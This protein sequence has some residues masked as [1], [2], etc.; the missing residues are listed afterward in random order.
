MGQPV[1]SGND[2]DEWKVWLFENAASG[3]GYLADQIAAAMGKAAGDSRP[4]PSKRGT[5]A[6]SL[7]TNSWPRITDRITTK[8]SPWVDLVAREVEFSPNA[9]REVYHAVMTPDYVVILALT[10]D[11]RIPLVRQ[12]RPAVEDFTLEFP[13]GIIDAGEDAAT[14]ARRE[15]L[16]ETGFPAKR[17]Y[18][19]GVNKT[20]AGRLSNRVHSYLIETAAQVPD[21]KPEEGLTTSLVTSSELLELVLRGEFDAQTDLGTVLLAVIHGRLKLPNSRRPAI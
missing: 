8:V 21:F 14:T 10:P 7:K 15:L 9:E 1:P 18:P 2:A 12:Y 4:M 17:V 5:D 13:A 19:L 11:G 16:E 6:T 3:T 20:D